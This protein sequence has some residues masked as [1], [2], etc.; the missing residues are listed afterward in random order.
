[1]GF[2]SRSTHVLLSLCKYI[3]VCRLFYRYSDDLLCE[4]LN[5]VWVGRAPCCTSIVGKC[6]I[7]G[8][9]PGL[10]LRQDVNAENWDTARVCVCVCV[11]VLPMALSINLHCPGEDIQTVGCPNQ[12]NSSRREKCMHHVYGRGSPTLHRWQLS[13]SRRDTYLPGV[14]RRSISSSPS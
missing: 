7:A 8:T 4:Y 6:L 12:K 5:G 2:A 1:M 14:S 13:S 10:T 3:C 11:C 9:D